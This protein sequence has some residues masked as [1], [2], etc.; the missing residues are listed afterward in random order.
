R[1][2]RPTYWIIGIAGGTIIAIGISASIGRVA[3]REVEG[4]ARTRCS[5]WPETPEPIF[6]MPVTQIQSG[7]LDHCEPLAEALLVERTDPSASRAQTRTTPD[8][9]KKV[10]RRAIL[11]RAAITSS[12]DPDADPADVDG[13]AFRCLLLEQLLVLILLALRRLRQQR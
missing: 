13:R 4:P 2:L 11:A 8:S 3:A 5:A 1:L 6:A 9:A 12:V 10:G 7:P